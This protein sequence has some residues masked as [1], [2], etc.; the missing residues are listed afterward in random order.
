MRRNLFFG[1]VRFEDDVKTAKE[2]ERRQWVEDLQRQV[3][4]NKNKRNFQQE[5]ERHQNFL[6][7]NIQPLLQEA[8]Y[9]HQQQ[10]QKEP[11]PSSTTNNNTQEQNNYYQNDTSQVLDKLRRNGYPVDLITKPNAGKSF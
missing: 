2:I 8:A 10:Q 5:T 1:D 3:E 4:E 6:H 9:R 11:S 7:Q